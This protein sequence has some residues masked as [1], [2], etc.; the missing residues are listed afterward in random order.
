MRQIGADGYSWKESLLDGALH[1]EKE[2]TYLSNLLRHTK[3]H[4]SFIR[5]MTEIN[6]TALESQIQMNSKEEHLDKLT[7]MYARLYVMGTVCL[8]C[9]WIMGE[10]DLT[11]Q[12]LAGI[13]QLPRT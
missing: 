12:E 13:C 11:P 9:E 1:F 5:Y 2:K 6:F 7:K 4:E 10:Y 3:G 8:T